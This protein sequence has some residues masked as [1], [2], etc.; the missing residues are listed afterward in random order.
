MVILTS[1]ESWVTKRVKISNM[2][3]AM[4]LAMLFSIRLTTTLWLKTFIIIKQWEDVSSKIQRINYFKKCFILNSIK[5]EKIVCISGASQNATASYTP[6][7]N[8]GLDFVALKF[9][10]F[11]ELKSMGVRTNGQD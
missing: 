6:L 8:V 4:Q 1:C 9:K 11:P 10:G 2:F 3:S 5:I 7:N